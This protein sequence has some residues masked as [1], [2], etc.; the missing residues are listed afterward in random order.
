MYAMPVDIAGLRM[1]KKYFF[2]SH[3]YYS[4][5]TPASTSTSTTT[6]NETV[7]LA[8]EEEIIGR[9]FLKITEEKLR[10]IGLGLGP[11]TVLRTSLRSYGVEDGRITDIPQIVSKSISCTSETEYH[12]SLNKAIAEE[13]EAELRK[14]RTDVGKEPK[15]KKA[16]VQEY[17]KKE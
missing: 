12:I 15:K 10:S 4:G 5:H 17:L 14:N 16:R 8:D 2:I 13:N 1:L 3:R 6:G 7:T 11:A 9:A